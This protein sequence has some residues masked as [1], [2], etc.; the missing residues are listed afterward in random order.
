MDAEE[1]TCINSDS[2]DCE[3]IQL[4]MTGIEV[5]IT[6]NDICSWLDKFCSLA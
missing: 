1:N 2:N 6:V 3:M 5:N 4:S